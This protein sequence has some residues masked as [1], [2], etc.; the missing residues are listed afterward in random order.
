[1]PINIQP[2]NELLQKEKNIDALAKVK[3]YL[4][5]STGGMTDSWWQRWH[6]APAPPSPPVPLCTQPA[7]YHPTQTQ[8]QCNT[9]E[10]NTPLS[11]TILT[12]TLYSDVTAKSQGTVKRTQYTLPRL[13]AHKQFRIIPLSDNVRCYTITRVPSPSAPVAMSCTL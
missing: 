13:C 9:K 11:S 6:V 5:Y 8:T 4:F 1:M 3:G 7:H 12:Q 2:K 10:Y